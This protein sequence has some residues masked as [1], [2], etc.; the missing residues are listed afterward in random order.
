MSNHLQPAATFIPDESAEYPKSNFLI[1]AK[2]RSSLLEN[3]ILAVSL[4][5]A[6]HFEY[7]D[8]DPEKPIRSRM[9]VSELRKAV[10]GNRGSFYQQL[11]DC[12]AAMTGKTIG[13]TTQDKKTFDYISVIT[14]ATCKDGEFTIEY[15]YTMRDYLLKLRNYT[16]LPLSIMMSFKLNHSLRLYELLR[17]QCYHR[18]GA[19]DTGNIFHIR[20]TVSELK[21]DLGVVN[22]DLDVVRK[23]LRSS[24][25]PDYDKAVAVSPEH[26]YDNWAEFRRRVLDP[27]V[28]EI[29]R[30]ADM[31]VQYETNKGGIGGKVQSIDFTVEFPKTSEKEQINTSQGVFSDDE[32]E[33]ILFDIKDV[34]GKGWSRKDVKAVAEAADYDMDK[35]QKAYLAFQ[36]ASG[37]KSP[38]AWMISAIRDGYEVPP[39]SD[40]HGMENIEQM[41]ILESQLIEN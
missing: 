18:K 30:V 23:V 39:A 19:A 12:A 38:V 26:M 4:S 22:A 32:K 34:L 24:K 37:V 25:T 27:A 14:R 2:Y 6:D 29:N 1:G 15:H 5:Q 31:H 16:R 17:S 3:K 28:N 11:N 13:M 10:K 9:K 40:I 21:L 7:D 41:T 20:F 8:D 35:V 36:A 33:D